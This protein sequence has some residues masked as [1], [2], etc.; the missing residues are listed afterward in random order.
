MITTMNNKEMNPITAFDRD[1]RRFQKYRR[2]RKMTCLFYGVTEGERT[3]RFSEN[4]HTERVL[5]MELDYIDANGTNHIIRSDESNLCGVWIFIF[6]DGRTLMVYGL[7][8]KEPARYCSWGYKNSSAI[9]EKL[10]VF[11]KTEND[12]YMLHLEAQH[13]EHRFILTKESLKGMHDNV[14]NIQRYIRSICKG[15]NEHEKNM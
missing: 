2:D 14:Q 9:A 4:G 11:W 6:P 13:P 5:H 8:D 1:V 3:I 12:S 15:E 10:H 7:N